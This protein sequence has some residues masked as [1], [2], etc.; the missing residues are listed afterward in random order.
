MQNARIILKNVVGRRLARPRREL[1][2]AKLRRL[3][4]AEGFAE[5]DLERFYDYLSVNL[6]L[7]KPQYSEPLQRPY[8]YFPG[9]SAQPTY[10]PAAFPWTGEIL[11]NFE[12]IRQELLDFSAASSPELQ[13][14]NLTDRGRWNVVYFYTGGRQNEAVRRACP[15]TSQILETIPGIGQAGQT[16]LS[17]LRAGT[18]IKQH[19]GPTNT[20]LRCHIG[21]VVPDG[22]R[23]RIGNGIH[24]W[25][26]GGC[27]LFDD[28]FQHEVWNDTDKDRLVLIIDFWHPDLTEA[29]RWAINTAR[30]L[31]FGLRDFPPGGSS[32]RA[33]F[34]R[35][36]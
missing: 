7:A 3:A 20:R 25:S 4:A 23:I 15:Q 31:R 13:A 34:G 11:R 35:R 29:E 2:W 26:E 21:L 32:S 22:P 17:I 33:L 6:K 24:Q 12:T 16:Y 19:F 5:Q 18:H 10:D 30:R 27:L 14:Q 8:N 9:L 28:S 1:I 36:G